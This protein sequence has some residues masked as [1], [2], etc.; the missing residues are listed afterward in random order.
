ML[1]LGLTVSPKLILTRLTT[2][3]SK[4]QEVHMP[5]FLFSTV[6]LLFL[7][8][9]LFFPDPVWAQSLAPVQSVADMFVD[10]L[11]GTFARSVAI[12]GL[13]GCGFLAMVGRMPW[14]A[15]LAVIAGIILVFGA[16]TIVDEISGLAG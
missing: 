14:G 13:A 7:F 12:I 6:T 5:R 3:E 8:A 10:F 11:T 9:V 16:A 4:L 15:A 1:S 2:A